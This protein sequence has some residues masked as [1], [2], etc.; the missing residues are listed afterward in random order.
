MY[1]H[2]K[3]RPRAAPEESIQWL[4]EAPI[5]TVCTRVLVAVPGQG[6]TGLLYQ[7]WH[8]MLAYTA[9]S[10]TIEL[11]HKHACMINF[12]SLQITAQSHVSSRRLKPTGMLAGMQQRRHEASF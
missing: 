9:L 10:K 8:N 4:I 2:A 11:L 6:L 1:L 7:Q 3:A 5:S 12:T